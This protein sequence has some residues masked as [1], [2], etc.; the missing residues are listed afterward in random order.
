MLSC[1]LKLLTHDMLSTNIP[2]DHLSHLV[3]NANPLDGVLDKSWMQSL[4]LV[5]IAEHP[6]TGDNGAK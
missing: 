1:S 3:R 6:A 2:E 5:A 4:D